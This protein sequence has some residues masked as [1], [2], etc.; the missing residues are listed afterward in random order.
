MDYSDIRAY[1]KPRTFLYKLK[2]VNIATVVVSIS[3]PI[4]ANRIS[5][6]LAVRQ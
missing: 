5:I 6:P 2:S 4:T 3:S 1:I